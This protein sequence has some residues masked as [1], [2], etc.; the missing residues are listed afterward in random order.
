LELA[1]NLR[2]EMLVVALIWIWNIIIILVIYGI[3]RV[4]IAWLTAG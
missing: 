1:V 3:Y 2:V 4:G